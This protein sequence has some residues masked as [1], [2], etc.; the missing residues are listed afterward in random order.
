MQVLPFIRKVIY[1]FRGDP[2]AREELRL[3]NEL[4]DEL[5]KMIDDLGGAYS[6]AQ[7]MRLAGLAITAGKTRAVVRDMPLRKA[8][9]EFIGEMMSACGSVNA[10]WDCIGRHDENGLRYFDERPVEGSLPRQRYVIFIKRDNMGWTVC[11]VQSVRP[12]LSADR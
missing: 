11:S 10:V 5:E 4:R 2:V 9:L 12:G 3:E 1:L 8:T 7:G 6:K